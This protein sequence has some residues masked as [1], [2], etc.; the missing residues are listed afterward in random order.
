VVAGL[1]AGGEHAWTSAGLRCC[2]DE[3]QGQLGLAA[4][5]YSRA[6]HISRGG[7]HPT[8]HAIAAAHLALVSVPPRPR[9]LDAPAGC[10]VA[11]PRGRASAD[12]IGR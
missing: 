9:L 6:A 11:R 3:A 5:Q 4:E 12:P 7:V 10:A 8:A 1:G 2:A